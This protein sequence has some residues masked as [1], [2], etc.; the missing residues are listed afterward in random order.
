MLASPE[1]RGFCL[2]LCLL[3]LADLGTVSSK[4]EDSVPQ[5]LILNSYSQDDPWTADVM[6]GFTKAIRQG[7]P[8]PVGLMIEYMDSKRYPDKENL[9]HLF[10]LYRYR[11]SQK[12]LDEVVVFGDPALAFALE[13]RKDLFPG[14]EMIFAG[15]QSYNVSSILGQERIAGIVEVPEIAET[16]KAMIQLHP[17]AKHLLV[18]LGTPEAANASDKKLDEEFLPFQDV[19]SIRLLQN[20]NMSQVLSEVQAVDSNSIILCAARNLE[21]DGR[22]INASEATFEISSHSKVPVWGLWEFQLGHGI[23]GGKLASGSVQGMNAAALALSL[24]NGG[25]PPD[26]PIIQKSSSALEF[27]LEQLRRFGISQRSLPE[28]S[29]LINAEPSFF[30]KNG[31]LITAFATMLLSIVLGLMAISALNIRRRSGTEKELKESERKYRELAVQLP[32]T[33]FEL[34]AFG[35]IVFINSFGRQMLGYSPS[36]LRAGLNIMQVI[37]KEDLERVKS[38]IGLAIRGSPQVKEYRLKK[39]DGST[40]PAIAYSMPIIKEGRTEGLRGIFLDISERK[41]TELALRESENKFRVLAEKSLVGIYILQDGRFKYV[42]PRFAEMFGYS[43]K[44]VL[45]KGPKEIL[46]AEDWPRVEE[47]L[48]LKLAANEREPLYLEIR[49]LTKRGELVYVEVFGSVTEYESRTAV[50]GTALDITERKSIENDLLRAK[51]EAEAAAKAK[52][53]FLANMSHEIRTPMNAVIGMTS[54]MLGTE[55]NQEQRE[56]IETIRYSG[57]ALLSVINDILDFSRIERG[58]IELEYAPIQLRSCIEEA[59]TLISSQ[60]S[61]KGL[62]LFYTV[63]AGTP[64][65]VLGDSSRIRQVLANLLSNS[66]K[67][68]QR[69]E[70]EVHVST[71]VQ[72]NDSCELHFSVRD[73]GIGISQ[74]TGGRLFQPFSQADAST[75]RKYGGTGLGLAI[76]KRLVELMGGRIWFESIEGKGSTFHFTIRAKASDDLPKRV[77]TDLTAQNAPKKARDL[78]ILLA[79]DNMVNSRMATLMIKKLGYEVD[80]VANG[81]EVLEALE[82]QPYDLILMDV[83]MPEM[84]G[85]E[86]TREIRRRWPSNGPRIVAF[87]AYAIQGD[88]EK[89]LEAGMDDYLSKPINLEDLRAALERAS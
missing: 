38:D 35:D 75:S 7:S 23:I 43:V 15:V 24:L 54:L 42:N 61:E 40:F 80:S 18:V 8:G 71:S 65:A 70:I 68:T 3:I 17:E 86:A 33:V 82:R 32:Q 63:E 44:E 77:A 10:D 11:Y 79:E 49:G 64:E 73:T 19:L 55:L 53:E 72:K 50:V 76:S 14:A 67:F 74:E 27:D 2:I 6:M 9:R 5:V 25:N 12:N 41:R 39:K 31:S 58:K 62:K 88:R 59:L 22:I 34:D 84:D 4:A 21:E 47:G 83:Q 29:V 46:L 36:D 81:R 30:E 45:E 66:V 89:C 57:Q 37:A 69:G 51:E 16:L 87:T 85:L 78:R 48:Q 52:S 26:P 1:R 60:A 20:A 56:Y 28:G 13:H